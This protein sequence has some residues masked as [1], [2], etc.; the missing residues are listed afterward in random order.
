[1]ITSL[2]IGFKVCIQKIRKE[3]QFKDGK[4]NEQLD[5]D[6]DPKLSADRAHVPE[7][8]VIEVKNPGKD[9]LLQILVF[10][11]PKNNKIK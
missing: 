1:M 10:W 8:V 4:H 2:L 6:N 11:L 7:A 9:V 3:E 5:Q